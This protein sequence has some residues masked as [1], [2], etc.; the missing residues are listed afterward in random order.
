MKHNYVLVISVLSLWLNSSCSIEE[1]KSDLFD[2]D[3]ESTLSI[4]N[5][6]NDS[7][8]IYLENWFMFPW[9]EQKLDTVI[10]K[11]S[12]LEIQLKT[13]SGSY[14]DLKI[15]KQEFKL[16]SKP[17][18]IDQVIIKSK[19]HIAF[20][21]DSKSI[22]DFLFEK[23]KAFNSTNSDYASRIQL[24]SGEDDFSNLVKA[25]DSI[26]QLHLHHLAKY[27]GD[28]PKWY[29]DFEGKRLK[30]VNA[31]WKLN[32]L[33]YRSKMLNKKD[34]V[35]AGFLKNTVKSIA[36][37][38]KGMIG[39][40]RYT[41]FLNDYIATKIGEK[42]KELLAKN[43]PVDFYK[44]RL[45][46]IKADLSDE[47]K[48][49]F[50]AFWFEHTIETKRNSFQESWLTD[51]SDSIWR[52]YLIEKIQSN[53][54]LPKGSKAPYFYLMDSTNSY[55]A[56]NNFKGKIVLV[57]F[58]ATWC[59][60]CIK[61]FPFENELV[62][63]F[64]N[65]A[66]EIVNICVNSDIDKWKKYI[67]KYDLK[68]TNLFAQG[69]W[70]DQLEEDFDIGGLPHDILIDGEWNVIENRGGRSHSEMREFIREVLENQ[71]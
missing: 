68:T 26:T 14:V 13:Q 41:L 2:L 40:S 55:Y 37:N 7:I 63:E 34:S 27:K 31:G 4:S 21:G 16:F 47:V 50:L 65:E 30:Y 71:K 29:I 38:D 64:E 69:N 59:M 67:K 51:I 54:I 23:S 62:K 28:L 52:N 46:V 1:E 43:Q 20:K 36:I 5:E 57:N 15:S 17:N 61:K 12:T 35:P 3:G 8:E 18:S 66:V 45:E 32:T 53:P 44:I 39:N 33:S 9:E 22:N 48:D 49:A 42:R 58:W 11:G 10:S 70:N 25:S 24:T 19:D 60:P 6:T 56:P